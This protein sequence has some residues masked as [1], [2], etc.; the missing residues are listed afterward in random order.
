MITHYRL[1]QNSCFRTCYKAPYYIK[2]LFMLAF[3]ALLILLIYL[4]Y[5]RSDGGSLQNAV[6]IIR[7]LNSTTF[8]YM[9][10]HSHV[11][12]IS[13]DVPSFKADPNGVAQNVPSVRFFSQC[14]RLNKPC[15]FEALAKQWPAYQKWNTLNKVDQEDNNNNNGTTGLGYLEGLLGGDQEVLTFQ[16]Q[17]IQ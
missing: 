4:I 10:S 16:N 11:L 2:N 17:G 6:K 5:F 7:G 3:Q 12:Q 15:I 9:E 8:N 14:V 13:N 1:K